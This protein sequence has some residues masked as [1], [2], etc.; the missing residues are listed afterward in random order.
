MAT[1]YCVEADIVENLRGVSFGANTPVTT[2]ALG[3]MIDQ[4]S[5]VIDQHIQGRY[6]IPVVDVD[7]LVFLKKICIDL[8]IYRVTKVL[9]PKNIEPIPNKATQDI[10]HASAWRVSMK[11]LK[12]LR[13]GDSVMPNT[14]LKGKTLVSSTQESDNTIASDSTFLR[15]TRQW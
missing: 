10:S 8:V 7:A 4:E 9:R 15:N 11:M 1:P 5:Q 6:T 14:D 2:T 3:N 12:D 13:A